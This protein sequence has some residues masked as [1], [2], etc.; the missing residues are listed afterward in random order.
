M[1][2]STNPFGLH[3]VTPYLVV[4]DCTA[5]IDFISEVFDVQTRDPIHRRDDGSIQHAEVVIGDCVVMLGE[6]EHDDSP[7]PSMLYVY[8]DDCDRRI[9]RAVHAGAELVSETRATPRGDRIGCIRDPFG[10]VWLL[11]THTGQQE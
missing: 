5:L 10:V 4:A 3:T 6:P 2:K 8:V 9:E 1:S 7:M 11:V